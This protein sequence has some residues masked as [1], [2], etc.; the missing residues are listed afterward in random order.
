M[1]VGRSTEANK[2]GANVPDRFL[3]AVILFAM[4]M[5]PS[6]SGCSSESSTIVA[7]AP[8]PGSAAASAPSLIPAVTA[9][10]TVH[11]TPDPS[12]AV[13]SPADTSV[14]RPVP[15]EPVVDARLVGPGIG[16]VET[17]GS[18]LVTRD[19]GQTWRDATPKGLTFVA[20]DKD[21]S[22]FRALAAV[23]GQTAFIASD[24]VGAT[25]TTVRMRAT[26]DGGRSWRWTD[27][28][29]MPHQ[30]GDICGDSCNT[31]GHAAVQID[32]VDES[33]VFVDLTMLS[34][35]DTVSHEVFRSLDGGAS[36]HRV[37]WTIT[38]RYGSDR[39]DERIGFLSAD[40]GAVV[41]EERFF[42]TRTGW[43]NWSE[44]DH[45]YLPYHNEVADWHGP[46]RFLDHTH[47]IIAGHPL[48]PARVGIP[49]ALSS[50]AGRT[51]TVETRIVPLVPG[52]DPDVS[53]TFLDRTT[54]V[55][56][57]MQ[58]TEQAGGS[59]LPHAQVWISADAGHHWRLVGDEPFSIPSATIFA[60]AAHAWAF[61][62][63]GTLAATSDGG[64][65]W[66]SILR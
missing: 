60:D 49:V 23:D 34:G 20:N 26:S 32:A 62:S 43:G 46:V 52:S 19:D 9:S 53:V 29:G 6:I 40:V 55:V 1:G 30:T 24:S 37:P 57:S 59:G 51:W 38:T 64:T 18:L 33:I 27:L 8:P 10:A 56:S 65:S 13:P 25:K 50:D 61:T 66:V 21:P 39:D 5:L 11:L 22:T 47:W 48:D 3:P 17:E 63:G 2:R 35:T 41:F 12:S 44:S 31:V 42:S 36:W 54:W 4:A 14:P 15:D 7:S 45:Y 58:R 16:W 28:P